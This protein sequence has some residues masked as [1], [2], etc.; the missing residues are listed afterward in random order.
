VSGGGPVRRCYL[1]KYEHS[2]P[3]LTP[4]RAGII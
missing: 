2:L 1:A 3:L 4:H